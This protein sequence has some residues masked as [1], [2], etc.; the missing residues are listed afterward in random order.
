RPAL[1]PQDGQILADA[2][3]FWTDPL[4]ADVLA[5][6]AQLQE[7]SGRDGRSVTRGGAGQRVT[8]FQSSTVGAVNA[9]PDARQVFT[10]D[11]QQP[12]ELLPLDAS[13]AVLAQITAQLDPADQL[14]D[15]Q[16]LDLLRWIRGQDSF[17]GDGDHLDSRSWLLGAPLHSR[18]LAINYGARP[19]TGYSADN[20]DIR[21]FFGSNDG[22][23]HQ[24]QNTTAAGDESGRETWAFIPPEL[25]AMQRH[26]MQNPADTPQSVPYGMDGEAVAL[27][28]DRDRDGSIETD[29]GDAVTVVIGQ[30][31]GGRGLYAF[32]MSDPDHP[33]FSW[34]IDN[35]TPGF[36][37]LALTF[38]TPRVAR[39]DLG[40]SA[41]TP[42]LVF[43]G[44]YNGGWDGAERVGKDA[45]A[46]SDLIGNAIYVVDP[47]DGR[48][49]WRALGPGGGADPASSEQLHFV[50]TL[51]DSIPSPL[52][53]I[54]SD[55]NGV[56]DRAYVG[57]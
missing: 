34:K 41:P 45:G 37:Q 54:D 44:G 46:G 31:R 21:I 39:L 48:L 10:L 53:L 42:V 22:F 7:V 20:P 40:G 26:L 8:G 6:D 14:S 24:L 28:L 47:A 50:P 16:E 36:E 23:L 1:S 27:V 11:P 12:G 4:G 43:A 13:P 57:D 5:F 51:T 3:T 30:R 17:D 52:T 25:L 18:P 15:A 33:R 38:S 32:D 29:D 55:R 2:L 56:D 35:L 49:I 19:G 9:D